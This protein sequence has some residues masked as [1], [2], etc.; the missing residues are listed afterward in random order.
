[1]FITREIVSNCEQIVISLTPWECPTG[2]TDMKGSFKITGVLLVLLAPC[3]SKCGLFKVRDVRHTD[4][5]IR[6]KDTDA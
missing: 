6:E 3:E 2:N 1:M 4:A 5:D